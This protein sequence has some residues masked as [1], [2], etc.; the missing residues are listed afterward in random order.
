MTV[1]DFGERVGEIG[2]GI[3]A[4]QFAGLDQ[5][6]DRGPIF[7]A[8]VRAGEERVLAIESDGPDRTLDRVGVDFD[9]AVVEEPREALPMR[10]RIA[11]R[12]GELAFPADGVVRAIFRT[13]S[14]C[15]SFGA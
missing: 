9:A 10:Q 15:G 4:A 1:D 8:A 14:G 12:L 13:V 11:D 6:R 3:D 5:R 2:V 7:S